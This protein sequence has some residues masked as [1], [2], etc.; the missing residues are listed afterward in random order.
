MTKLYAADSIELT[1][2]LA[3]RFGVTVHCFK[4]QDEWHAEGRT[5]NG[6]LM[7]SLTGKTKASVVRHLNGKLTRKLRDRVKADSNLLKKMSLAVV[8]KKPS[9]KAAPLYCPK[10]GAP[11]WYSPV[12]SP[13]GYVCDCDEKSRKR[14]SSKAQGIPTDIMAA[15][16]R[17]HPDAARLIDGGPV[18]YL[19]Q[20]CAW[21]G[22]IG[23]TLWDSETN[24]QHG[25]GFMEFADDRHV[26]SVSVHYHDEY[27]FVLLSKSFLKRA[28]A[29]AGKDRQAIVREIAALPMSRT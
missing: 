6:L 13:H 2:K 17:L 21:L 25:Y 27:P 20:A 7:A 22:S 28:I 23:L 1:K 26:R 18:I 16:R 8:S 4:Q 14:K 3:A 24:P 29:A 19:S 10:C 5:T 9:K 15:F 11:P 12:G